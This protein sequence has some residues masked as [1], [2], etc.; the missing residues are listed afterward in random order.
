MDGFCK[1]GFGVDIN[2]LT[3]TNSGA[4]TANSLLMSRYFDVAWKLKRYFNFLSEA[5]M[6]DNI[7]TVDDF[8]YKVIHSRKQE[9]SVQNNYVRGYPHTPWSWFATY[10]FKFSLS[11]S[12]GTDDLLSLSLAFKYIYRW[13]QTYCLALLHSLRKN[14]RIALTSIYEILFWIS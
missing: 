2:S 1:L 14:Q 13:N 9:V 3:N 10:L 7:K 11:A 4:D 5:T 6:K 12:A 8:V